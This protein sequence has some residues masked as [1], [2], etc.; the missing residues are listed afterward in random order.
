MSVPHVDRKLGMSGDGHISWIDLK[1]GQAGDPIELHTIADLH[2]Q[3]LGDLSGATVLLQGSNVAE[4]GD[5][6]WS[7]LTDGQGFPLQ[8]GDTNVLKRASTIPW[9]VRPFIEG[10]DENTNVSMLIVSRKGAR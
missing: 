4:P 9:W 3:V 6:D 7:S 10:G 2:I 8:F 5:D 1:S